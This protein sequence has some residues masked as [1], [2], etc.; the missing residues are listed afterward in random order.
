MI[1]TRRARISPQIAFLAVVAMSFAIPHAAHALVN[2]TGSGFWLGTTYVADASCSDPYGNVNTNPSIVP[3]SYTQQQQRGWTLHNELKVRYGLSE[4]SVCYDRARC[5]TSNSQYIC[6]LSVQSCLESRAAAR[7]A[8]QTQQQQVQSDWNA[9][10]EARQT[11]V[12]E[13][14]VAA[15]EPQTALAPV[16]YSM[17]QEDAPQS[18]PIQKAV[19]KPE[20]V[21]EQLPVVTQE[22]P[23]TQEP[24]PAPQGFWSKAWGFVRNTLNPFSWF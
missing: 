4:F 1:Y 5:S 2:C 22:T 16:Q 10:E 9:L 21:N 14:P 19:T 17:P 18:Q 6:A 3:D 7:G 12:K 13:E 8:M 11:L 20:L 24:T 15:P 23:V